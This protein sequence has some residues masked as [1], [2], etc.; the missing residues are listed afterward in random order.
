MPRSGKRLK[1]LEEDPLS[2]SSR[3]ERRA[4]LGFSGL[5]FALGLCGLIPQKI[6]ALG[7]EI[8]GA[9]QNYLKWVLCG[10]VAYFFVAFLIYSWQDYL[11]WKGKIYEGL[12]ADMRQYWEAD[13]IA[14]GRKVAPD[15]SYF[16]K[17]GL[18]KDGWK[19]LPRKHTIKR[20]YRIY[21]I[22]SIFE[23]IFPLIIGWAAII[24]IAALDVNSAAVK[25]DS[26][27]PFE[28]FFGLD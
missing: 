15:D 10:L 16:P 21:Y 26:V 19:S 8:G 24:Y 11:A 2:E 14:Q 7:V 17:S 3:K 22:R 4:L 25:S 27:P 9:Q 20:S 28:V 13:A 6:S 1:M 23:F 18:W 12:S 5:A